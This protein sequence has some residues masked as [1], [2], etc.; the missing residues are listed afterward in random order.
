MK[1]GFRGGPDWYGSEGS[2]ATGRAVPGRAARGMMRPVLEY[3]REKVAAW[4]ADVGDY[5][6]FSR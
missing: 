5:R 3:Q 2:G 1:K 6:F 4:G